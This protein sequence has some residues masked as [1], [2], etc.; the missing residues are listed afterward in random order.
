MNGAEL[1][2]GTALGVQPADMSYNKSNSKE[3]PSTQNHQN[4][5]NGMGEYSCYLTSISLLIIF[6]NFVPNLTRTCHVV[7]LGDTKKSST[8]D[9]KSTTDDKDEKDDADS[10]DGVIVSMNGAAEDLDDFFASLV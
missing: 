4:Y 5:V 10:K 3:K 1:P 8:Q 6:T 9:S 7:E 2:C